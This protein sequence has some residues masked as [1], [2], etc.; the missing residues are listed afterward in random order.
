MCS[1]AYLYIQVYT[2]DKDTYCRSKFGV[3][4]TSPPAFLGNLSVRFW[5]LDLSLSKT[6]AVPMWN[7]IVL[8]PKLHYEG[9]DRLKTWNRKQE[10]G[11]CLIFSVK[12]QMLLIFSVQR[13]NRQLSGAIWPAFRGGVL[14][15]QTQIAQLSPWPHDSPGLPKVKTVG[16]PLRV[17]IG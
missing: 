5:A 12:S 13:F 14:R 16:I 4:T 17:G 15:V 8:K 3:W 6:C 2:H 10:S 9:S 7:W 1:Y 11:M